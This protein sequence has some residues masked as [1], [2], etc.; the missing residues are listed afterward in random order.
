MIEQ[1]GY[2]KIL[3][4]HDVPCEVYFNSEKGTV[5][6]IGRFEKC[7]WLKASR[8]FH[9]KAMETR[10][11]SGLYSKIQQISAFQDY[12]KHNVPEF[13]CCAYYIS[14]LTPR[15]VL[16]NFR[17]LNQLER[18]NREHDDLSET[19]ADTQ[20]EQMMLDHLKLFR[21]TG[22]H[23]IAAKQLELTLSSRMKLRTPCEA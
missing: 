13:H 8:H 17:A 20:D 5:L 11:D 10:N 4:F 15:I 16:G 21:E 6:S 12:L 7:C 23:D 19:L 2:R 22:T 3:E 1:L 18:Y 14:E 9:I